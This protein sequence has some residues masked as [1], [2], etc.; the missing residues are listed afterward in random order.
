MAAIVPHFGET[1]IFSV[2]TLI[3]LL[4]ALQLVAL[5]PCLFVMAFLLITARDL[6]PV[7]VP[8]LYFVALA[9][10]F[11][12]P[13]LGV[14]PQLDIHSGSGGVVYGGLIF[15][16]SLLPAM[17]FLL[18]IQFATGAIPRLPY[19]GILALPLIGG[20]GVVYASLLADELCFSTYGCIP[21]AAVEGLYSTFSNALIFL[22]L[23]ASF[24]HARKQSAPQVL[25]SRNRYW[26]IVALI[27]LNLLVMGVDLARIGEFM[28]QADALFATT[29]LRMTFIYVVLTLLFRVFDVSHNVTVDNAES[30]QPRK[31]TARDVK[32]REIIGG[33]E[34]LMEEEQ[35]YREMECGRETVAK[36]LS[37]NE[38]TLSRII[39]QHYKLRFT[40]VVNQYRVKEAQR[41]LVANPKQAVTDIAFEVGFNSIPS[42]NRVF[43]ES[44]G[45][46]PSEYRNTRLA[47]RKR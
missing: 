38:N 16:Q 2:D 47:A 43:K 32:D 11:M 33:F 45:F 12:L 41:L 29:L 22:L 26:L 36:A 31:N 34:A 24:A 4:Q 23:V 15:V 44:S 6:Q 13:L 39:N 27:G 18:I 46:S 14:W 37:V 8:C 20:S 3:T 17:S 35:L 30:T 19:W 7:I 40:D 9:C 10:S 25:D 42:F 5:A 1:M 28:Q 21:S